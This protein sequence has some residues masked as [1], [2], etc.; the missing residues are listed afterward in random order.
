MKSHLVYIS[1][2][3]RYPL[4][5]VMRTRLYLCGLLLKITLPHFSIMRNIPKTFKVIKNKESEKLLQEGPK[6]T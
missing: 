4:K 3:S 1:T 6:E 2:D 5:D